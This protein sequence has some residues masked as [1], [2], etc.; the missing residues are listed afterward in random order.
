M[1]LTTPSEAAR[2]YKGRTESVRIPEHNLFVLMEPYCGAHKLAWAS[3]FKKC[4]L[5]VLLPLLR[6]K[7]GLIEVKSLD[8]LASL[9]A[10]LEYEE[11]A[12]SVEIVGTAVSSL[13]TVQEIDSGFFS[14]EASIMSIDNGRTSI[15]GHG[16]RFKTCWNYSNFAGKPLR[17][18][19]QVTTASHN[20][21]YEQLPDAGFD[22]GR[23][24]GRS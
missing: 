2:G 14:Q 12:G 5:E 21:R 4:N 3:R 16:I 18:G 7:D 22:F 13:S 24:S 15:Q 23:Q 20:S 10:L 8:I 9:P 11:S 6:F 19:N 1:V 17:S